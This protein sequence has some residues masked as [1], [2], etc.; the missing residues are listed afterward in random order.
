MVLKNN[1]KKTTVKREL[2]YYFCLLAGKVR[3][4]WFAELDISLKFEKLLLL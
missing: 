3:D 2:H 4:C 1:L